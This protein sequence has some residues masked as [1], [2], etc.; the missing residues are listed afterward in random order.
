MTTPEDQLLDEMELTPQFKA[1]FSFEPMKLQRCFWDIETEAYPE[2]ELIPIMP[3]FTAPSNYKDVAAIQKAISEKKRQWIEDAALSAQTARVLCIGIREDGE[4]TC[5]EG[6]EETILHSFWS[7]WTSHTR[8]FIGFYTHQF[9]LPF[10]IQR[11]WKL[12]IPVPIKPF[13]KSWDVPNSKDLAEYWKCGSRDCHS[14]G[15]DGLACFFGLARKTGKGRDFAKL[16]RTNHGA[17]MLYLERD[18]EIIEGVAGR[19]GV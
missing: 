6:N 11:S 5:F 15:L 14:G 18:V 4:F 7:L 8:E 2:S 16:Y 12:G 3:E 17:A 19:M 10:L 1:N 9:D 13:T